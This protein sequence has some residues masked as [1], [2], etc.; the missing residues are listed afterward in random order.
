MTTQTPA[1]EI[2]HRLVETFAQNLDSYR[3]NKNG[4]ELRRE[5][6]DR[7]FAALGW[8][9]ANE[10]GYDGL[11][12]EV[13]HEFSVEVAGQQKKADYA[14]RVGRGDRFD[15]LVEAM[16][17]LHKRL[18]RAATPPEKEGLERQIQATDQV[19]DA[20][21][22]KLNGLSAEKIKLAEGPLL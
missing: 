2:I 6:L 19:I 20:L 1:P 22:Y 9:V 15:F 21:V 13:V 4:T 16:L 10:K 8:D 11:S 12:K 3:S 14:F 18:A 5:F 17:E 7:S